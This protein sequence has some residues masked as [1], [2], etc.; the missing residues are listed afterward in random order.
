[1]VKPDLLTIAGRDFAS[2]LLLGSAGYPNQQ[3]LLDS[4]Q[5][6]DPALVTVAIRRISLASY[7]ESL[8]DVLAG[9]V[10]LPNT[11]G[12]TTVRD[13]VLT[14]ELGR[15]ALGT[16]WVKLELI[17]DTETL[18]PDAEL[19]LRATD[20]LVA[21]GFVVLPYCTDDPVVCRKLADAGA[22]AVM[23]LGSPI[24]TGLGIINPYAIER[25][26]A[27]SPVPVILDAGIGTASDAAR[28]MELGCAAV[29]LNTAVAKARDPARMAYAMATAVRAGRAARLA[30]RTPVRTQAEPSSP[31]LGLL[32]S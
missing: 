12:C 16:D 6:A 28:A 1:M 23:P 21:K 22:A 30:G 7:A 5:A 20:E 18:Y 15:E 13:A 32:G 31:Q 24:G 2:R 14:A 17:G 26:C 19:L 11:A 25:I 3:V 9:R 29:L 27:N 10:L 4:V 8:I